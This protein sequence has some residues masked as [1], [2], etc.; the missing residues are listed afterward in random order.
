MLKTAALFATVAFLSAFAA[1]PSGNKKPNEKQISAPIKKPEAS[2]SQPVRISEGQR[3]YCQVVLYCGLPMPKGYCPD[4]AAIGPP[5]FSFDQTRCFEARQL[6]ARG[7][8]PDHPRVGYRLYRFLGMEYRVIYQV[9]DFIPISA[10]RLAYL[11]QD[12]PLAAKLISY[13]RNAPYSAQY[14]DLQHKSFSGT[15][16]KHLKGEATLI[17][18]DVNEK[19][20][21]YFG[22]GVAEVAWWVLKGPALMD[23]HYDINAK[24]PKSVHYVMKVLVF[25]G[26]GFI[27]K[28]MNLGLFRKIVLSKIREV[29]EDI[30]ETAISLA[31]SGG[32][33]ILKNKTF[34]AEE[35]TKI[36]TFL[37]L[38]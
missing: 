31:K 16:G 20:L 17:S 28:I 7:V 19:H 11:L 33:D 27:N 13:Y 2:P 25:P 9:E 8:G 21:F 24:D 6:S 32:Q 18:G 23:F 10:S 22:T 15:K 34:T 3:D 35:K 26:S 38:P 5:R 1:D 12:L 37:K 4:S 29:L 36:E 14:V 30:T